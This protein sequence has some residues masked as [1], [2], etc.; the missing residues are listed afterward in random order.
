MD[1][2]IKEEDLNVKLEE[3]IKAREEI[4]DLNKKNKLVASYPVIDKEFL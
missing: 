2:K 1:D 3:I 4:E